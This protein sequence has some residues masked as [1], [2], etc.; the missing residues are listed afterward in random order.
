MRKIAEERFKTVLLAPFLFS[1]GSHVR[2]DIMNG[3]QSWRRELE[4]KG[5]AVSVVPYGLSRYPQIA[6]MVLGRLRQAL[7]EG[8]AQSWR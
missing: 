7:R 5:V 1:V 6:R 4:E 3:S 8:D 2:N